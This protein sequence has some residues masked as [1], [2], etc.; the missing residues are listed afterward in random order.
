MTTL[1]H[2]NSLHIINE[3]IAL[4]SLW[5]SLFG[6]HIILLDLN[7]IPT[8]LLPFVIWKNSEISLC[9]RI[10]TLVFKLGIVCICT[11]YPRKTCQRWWKVWIMND[12][13]LFYFRI[14]YIVIGLNTIGLKILHGQRWLLSLSIWILRLRIC[15]EM[16]SLVLTILI[17]IQIK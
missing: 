1:Q 5:K 9:H 6:F 16:G 8:Q 2:S 13:L 3:W 7:T 14:I 10:G 11:Y 17:V 12:K 4:E 15:R